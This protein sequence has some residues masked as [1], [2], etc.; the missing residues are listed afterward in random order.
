MEK[1][2][3]YLKIGLV[4]LSIL[5]L[6]LYLKDII[7]L[8]LLIN[9]SLF[10]VIALVVVTLGGAL[11]NFFE[12]PKT[13]IRFFIGLIAIL[14][15]YFIGYQMSSDSIDPATNLVIPGS[16]LSE[17]GIYTCYFLFVVGI[18]AILQSTIKRIFA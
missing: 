18:G 17:A 3:N 10:L 5:M 2:L 8:E 13:G 6:V 16:K 4:G 15:F 14:I 9:F 12:N 7:T 11:F 1:I